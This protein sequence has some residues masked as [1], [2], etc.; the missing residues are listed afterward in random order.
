M[1]APHYLV[2]ELAAEVETTAR[3]LLVAHPL[4]AGDAI[5]LASCLELA[6]SLHRKIELVCFDDRLA[7]AARAE[8][9]A[10]LGA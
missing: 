4:R 5:H 6:R 2:L 8:G 9:V 7:A 1:D 3:R 10:V